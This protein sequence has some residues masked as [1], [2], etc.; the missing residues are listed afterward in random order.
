MLCRCSRAVFRL[1]QFL[2]KLSKKASR[3]PEEE[4]RDRRG[5]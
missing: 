1:K 2:D 4:R 3:L 5:S